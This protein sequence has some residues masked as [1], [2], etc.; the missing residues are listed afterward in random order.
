MQ[1]R[2]ISLFTQTVNQWYRVWT[3]GW[4]MD[5]GIFFVSTF[6]IVSLQLGTVFGAIHLWSIGTIQVGT[7]VLLISYLTNFV[8][9]V[10][11]INFMYR[12]LFRTAGD[13]AEAIDMMNEPLAIVDSPDATKLVVSEGKIVFDQINFSYQEKNETILKN[14]SLTVNP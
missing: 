1:R 12:N 5:N 9:Q 13:M 11:E 14:F 2:E 7:F 8:D 3:K 10:V 6:F 4:W